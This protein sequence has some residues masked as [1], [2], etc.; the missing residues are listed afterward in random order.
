MKKKIFIAGIFL[1]IFSGFNP[2]FIKSIL[3]TSAFAALPISVPLY[4]SDRSDFYF[5]RAFNKSKEGD[6]NGAIKDYTKV[7]KI[8]PKEANAFYNRG[9]AKKNINDFSGAI[10]DF[11]SS[12]KINP[13]DKEA[14]YM[15]GKS[16]DGN[17]DYKGAIEDLKKAIKVDPNYVEAHTE[18]GFVYPK[19]LNDQ[20]GS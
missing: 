16:K 2:V 20:K 10:K 3:L 18:I 11:T 7:I 4:A 1:S 13:N 9:L 6:H 15:R 8:N 14:Y 5:N 12:L 19:R 17:K